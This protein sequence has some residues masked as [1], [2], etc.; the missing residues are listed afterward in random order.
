[1]HAEQIAPHWPPVL[2][3][4]KGARN[5][6]RFQPWEMASWRDSDGTRQCGDAQAVSRYAP[7]TVDHEIPE[8]T[9]RWTWL[10]LTPHPARVFDWERYISAPV[11]LT[12][13]PALNRKV[14]EYVGLRDQV[15][16]ASTWVISVKR[17][18]LAPRSVPRT[19]RGCGDRGFC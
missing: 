9:N 2:L 14:I 6:C 1:M 12:P 15:E 7:L 13:P 10:P 16:A 18:Q 8:E 3:A 17:V 11:N 19:Y 5:T 4:E